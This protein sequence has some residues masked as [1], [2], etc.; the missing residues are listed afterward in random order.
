MDLT[1]AELRANLRDPAPQ[2]R[3]Y[4]MGAL[5]REA[6]TRD[7][8]LFVTPSEIREAW[9]RLQRHLDRARAMSAFLLPRDLVD[10]MF[11]DR[12]GY[13]PEADLA[14]LSARTPA[15]IRV[16]SPG[17]WA[18]SPSSHCRACCCPCSPRSCGAFAM[19]SATASADLPF[20]QRVRTGDTALGPA[21]AP[22]AGGRW[23][24]PLARFPTA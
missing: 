3:A 8:W 20:P 19:T 16:C 13:P 7:V 14:L 12:A 9:P 10:L 24:I 23:V 2:V 15:W 5:L 6:N 1:V 11:F 22:A 21:S 17:C 4:F 18:S